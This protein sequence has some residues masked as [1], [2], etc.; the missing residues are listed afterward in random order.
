MAKAVG[1]GGILIQTKDIKRLAAWYKKHLGVEIGDNETYTF[2]YQREHE[3]PEIIRKTLF[4]IIELEN[5]KAKPELSTMM[6]S[7][8]VD[9][10]QA[11]LSQLRG[12]GVKVEDEVRK[13]NDGWLG[14]VYD[15]DG[16]KIE[17]WVHNC[18]LSVVM[19]IVYDIDGNKIE[20][21]E[22]K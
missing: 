16:N 3:N 13:V 19:G 7:F 14:W 4:E 5:E 22:H 6:L 20:L 12:S 1:I 11:L 9:N 10:L 8:R 18:N 21:W 15:I 2:F 17:L